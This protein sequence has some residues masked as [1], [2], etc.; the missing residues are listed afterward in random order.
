MVR[1]RLAA[2]VEAPHARPQHAA[3][4][5]GH[6]LGGG[7][8]AVQ[9]EP[10]ARPPAPP[11]PVVVVRHAGVA[12]QQRV[13]RHEAGGRGDHGGA[14]AK[15]LKHKL[16]QRPHQRRQVEQRLRHQQRALRRVDLGARA[17]A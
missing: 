16:V 15:V 12:V 9:H 17:R 5:H 1:Q 10:R 8:A 6:S 7:E 14:E 13:H 4:E 3:V 2:Q 11:S